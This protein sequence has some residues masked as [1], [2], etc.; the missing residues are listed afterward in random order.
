VLVGVAVAVAVLVAVAVAVAVALEVAQPVVVAFATPPNG[1][2]RAANA[3]EASR[4]AAPVARLASPTR[5]SLSQLI[6]RARRKII[7]IP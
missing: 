7:P 4:V 5:C 2:A 1:P 3:T 6:G